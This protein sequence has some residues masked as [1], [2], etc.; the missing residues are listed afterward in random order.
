MTTSFRIDIDDRGARVLFRRL[1]SNADDIRQPMEQIKGNLLASIDDNFK[2]QGRPNKWKALKP[3]T[4]KQRRK[5]Q[6]IQ[7]KILQASGGLAT[8]I[9]GRVEHLA[10]DRKIIVGSPLPYARIHN[11]GG[12]ISHPGGTKYKVIGPGKISFVKNSSNDFDGT[13][14]PHPIK[15]PKREFLLF[16]SRDIRESHVILTK[17]LLSGIRK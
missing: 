6:Q 9:N 4:I 14:K 7:T 3:S 2:M 8:S 17:H 16:Q 13:T 15:I 1:I 12:T 10:V 5:K 11:Q